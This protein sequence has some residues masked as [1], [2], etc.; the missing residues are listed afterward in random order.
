[1]TVDDLKLLGVLVVLP[2][3]IRGTGVGAVKH[4]DLQ[5]GLKLVLCF[6]VNVLLVA[7]EVDFC[8]LA[9]ISLGL[10]WSFWQDKKAVK[11][12]ICL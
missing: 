4:C 3:L 7:L 11:L 6:K 5:W 9:L 1:M 12:K 2:F 8:D 10:F